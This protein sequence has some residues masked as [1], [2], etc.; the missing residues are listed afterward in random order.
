MAD[1]GLRNS[2]VVG[3]IA[4]AD[5][6]S[7]IHRFVKLSAQNTVV[8]VTAATDIVIGVQTD[9][10][11][12]TAAGMPVSVKVAGQAYLEASEALAI[13]DIVGPS[14]DGSGQVAVAT[15]YPC[16]IV[17]QAAG[18]DGDLAIVELRFTLTAKAA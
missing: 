12:A 3:M 7:N 6:S 16:G 14:A 4:G 8:V 13:N 2:D 1:T 5:L 15:N 11:L 17:I 18:A 9:E 10:V